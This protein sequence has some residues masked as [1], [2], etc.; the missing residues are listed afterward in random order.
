MKNQ[1]DPAADADKRKSNY[2]SKNVNAE[3]ITDFKAS[4]T[5]TKKNNKDPGINEFNLTLKELA[6]LASM[7]KGNSYKMI[8]Y[9][10]NIAINTV[11]EHIRNIYQKLN[12]HSCM[13]AVLLALKKSSN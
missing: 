7:A 11:R 8:A 12:V 10:C 5:S 2:T 1:P 4:T 9:D 13:E 6:I 3:S